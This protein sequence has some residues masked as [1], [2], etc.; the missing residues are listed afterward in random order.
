MAT[1]NPPT[2][3]VPLIG[4]ETELERLAALLR[5]GG[6]LITL[7]GPPG[8]GKTRLAIEAHRGFEGGAAWVDLSTTTGSSEL[9]A[10]VAHG[11]GVRLSW[12]GAGGAVI[13]SL[14]HRRRVSGAPQVIVSGTPSTTVRH[15]R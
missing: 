15:R 14:C 3:L 9:C 11:L 13:F 1:S 7:L 2:T 4:R 8:I 5:G 12:L 6:R 10:R